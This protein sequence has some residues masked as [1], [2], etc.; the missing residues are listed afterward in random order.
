MATYE[1]LLNECF[2]IR[3]LDYIEIISAPLYLE[4]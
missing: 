4:R 1:A 2:I 3:I